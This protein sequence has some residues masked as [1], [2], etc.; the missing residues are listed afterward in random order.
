HVCILEARS[1]QTDQP[2]G[3][4]ANK[5]RQGRGG[6]PAKGKPAV[7]RQGGGGRRPGKRTLMSRA[8]HR[9]P[10][11]ARGMLDTYLAQSNLPPHPTPSGSFAT[12]MVAIPGALAVAATIAGQAFPVGKN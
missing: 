2:G 11:G 3:L 7:A 5:P 6:K 9:G 10:I 1:I 4:T 8:P 12:G